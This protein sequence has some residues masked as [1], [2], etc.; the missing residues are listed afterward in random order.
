MG[1]DAAQNLLLHLAGRDHLLV[2]A[3]EEG[4]A[5]RERRHQLAG[6]LV[7]QETQG[8]EHGGANLHFLE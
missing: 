7:R 3:E 4:E 5:A 6:G 1:L 2:V 8:G